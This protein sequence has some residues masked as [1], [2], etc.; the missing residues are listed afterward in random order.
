MAIDPRRYDPE[1]R[2]FADTERHVSWKWFKEPGTHIAFS[3]AT[4]SGKTTAWTDLLVR[5]FL[6]EPPCVKR[7]VVV[8]DITSGEMLNLA[9]HNLPLLVWIPE[10]C[11][12]D[13][14][15]RQFKEQE[16]QLIKRKYY[17]PTK[18]WE[19]VLDP[20][21]SDEARNSIN[22]IEYD[23]FCRSK[24]AMKLAWW[25]DFY[26]ALGEWKGQHRNFEMVLARDEFQ[27][28]TNPRYRG[29]SKKKEKSALAEEIS[30]VIIDLYRR[31]GIGLR[32]CF[33]PLKS[34]DEFLRPQF[35]YFIF[36]YMTKAEHIK[37]T[38][39]CAKW[40]ANCKP[41]EIVLFLNRA[42][43]PDPE[44][45]FPMPFE[46]DWWPMRYDVS[47]KTW[48]THIIAEPSEE[49]LNQAI[50]EE[51]TDKQRIHPTRLARG[52]KILHD[53]GL[54][55]YCPNPDC[56]NHV[57]GYLQ[58]YEWK[59]IARVFDYN[60]PQAVMTHINSYREA[61]QDVPEIPLPKQET[62]DPKPLTPKQTK[63]FTMEE[64][65]ETINEER[66][67]R[68]A[69]NGGNEMSEEAKEAFA[70]T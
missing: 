55:S 43:E 20:L 50:K 6:G 9:H 68:D 52:M 38:E 57:K 8:S 4:G 44:V 14:D 39:V 7:T 30:E 13:V 3:S 12:W 49:F 70:D 66:K 64:I 21:D 47:T 23:V 54:P 42:P 58:K 1:R 10:G 18:V 34:V 19:T 59:L 2:G 65:L 32:V 53:K 35:T 11:K 51:L 27:Q 69:G 28:H 16:L 56:V 31:N 40:T 29:G 17:D 60:S 36:K 41:D 15:H 37:A 62:L 63:K 25:H 61:E 5:D 45:N 26:V 67:K 46:R 24:R 48:K 22:L 33:N